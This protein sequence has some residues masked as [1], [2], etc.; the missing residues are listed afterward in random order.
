MF[1]E[2]DLV[3]LSALQHFVFCERQCALI[4]VE[5]LWVENRLTVEGRLLHRRAHAAPGP[6]GGGQVVHREGV[7]LARAVP[8]RSL[9]L[10]LVGVADVV[11]FVRTDGGPAGPSETVVPVE[12]KRGRP[13]SHD[14]DRIQLCAQALCLEE[15]LGVEVAHGAL[16][17]G[18]TR[19]RD[20]VGFDGPLRARTEE[21]TAQV[22]AMIAKGVTPRA[23]R[24]RKCERCSLLAVCLPDGAS[25][26]PSAA[27]YIAESLED[28]RVREGGVQ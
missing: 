8:L 18:R 14:A 22:H 16:Y 2:D 26:R 24:M 6:R 28:H 10:G 27:G 19:R 7:R 12:Y 23:R 3:P 11:E 15:M 25:K 9:R 13:K 4:H 20:L 21:V 5:R 17:Y 1:S